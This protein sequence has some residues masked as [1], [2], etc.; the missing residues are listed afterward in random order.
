MTLPEDRP[1]T[2]E[3]YGRAMRSSRLTVTPER[4]G[5]VDLLIAAGWTTDSLG[6]SLYRLRAE[7]DLARAQ[8]R[9]AD[10]VASDH[11][12]QARAL[13]RRAAT[14]TIK[15]ASATSQAAA[16]SFRDEA[17]KA[18]A[19]AKQQRTDA[20]NHARTEMALALVT[21][22]TLEP[23]ALSLRTFAVAMGTRNGFYDL[24]AIRKI[25]GRA[26]QL[27]LDPNC[28]HC[29]GR[30][31][32]GGRDGPMRWCQDCLR[33]GKR[34][35]GAPGFRLGESEAGHQLGRKLLTDMDRKT[36]TVTQQMSWFLRG[37]ATAAASRAE[38]AEAMQARLQRLRSSQ[39]QED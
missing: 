1:S 8:L 37:R 2:A 20:E 29:D 34:I 19:Q 28:P 36:E 22:K 9:R 26:L 32:N 17:T 39:A 33:T 16:D 12:G 27:W 30:G 11:A 24:P 35:N 13:V 21:L 10:E 38:V 31:F 7:W 18:S 25:A 6:A 15:A 4:A 5:D 14:A 3:R 23:T